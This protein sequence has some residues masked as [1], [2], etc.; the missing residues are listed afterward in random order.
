RKEVIAQRKASK[1]GFL[2]RERLLQRRRGS[3][4][5]NT[6]KSS[7]NDRRPRVLSVC[8]IRRAR[9]KE[10]YFGVYGEFKEASKEYRS[11]NLRVQFPHGTYPPHLPVCKP[12]PEENL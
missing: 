2:G 8:N 10:W 9:C 12:P 7:I 4:P 3:L 5:R 11:G 1:Q 6:K